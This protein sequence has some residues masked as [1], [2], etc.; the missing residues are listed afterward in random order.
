MKKILLIFIAIL[1]SV[2]AYSGNSPRIKFEDLLITAELEP[3]IFLEVRKLSAEQNLPMTIL[4]RDKKLFNACGIEDG[5]VVYAF[6]SD[7]LNPF[8]NGKT[9]FFEEV[10]NLFNPSESK[11][12]YGDGRVIDNTYGMFSP[13]LQS[14]SGVKEFL[15]VTDWTFDRVYLFDAQN[16]DLVDTAFIHSSNPQLQSPKHA[17]QTYYGTQILV[18]D[19]ISD[20]VQ[21]FDTN[22]LYVNLFAPAGGVNTSILDNIRGIAYKPNNHLL[23]TVASGASQNTIQEF[24]TAGVHVGSFITSNVNSPFCILYRSGD[25]LVSNSS[26]TNRITKFNFNGGF[27]SSFYTGTNFA[28]PQQ[29]IQLE[30]GRII[31]A[32]FSNPSGVVVLDSTGNFVR[33][34][35]AVTGIRGVYLLGNGNYMVTNSGGV[36]EIDS[37]SGAMI[38]TIVTGANYQYIDKYIPD[39]LVNIGN[40]PQYSFDYRLY[41]NYPNP[42]NPSTVIRFSIAKS[43][44][45]LLNIYDISGK[46]I[47]T[48]LNEVMS[49]GIH[50]VTFN[51]ENLSSGV[52]FYEIETSDFRQSRKM[53]LVK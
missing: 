2:P 45:V 21:R 26:G 44:N 27:I 37:L 11:I 15:M 19:Q 16:G 39:G 24:D 25:I 40:N 5:K 4:T 18:S 6:I 14:R 13:V 52:Y 38:R 53:L 49:P 36:H 22:G 28:F 47:K 12:I 29:I 33:I 17:M 1:F 20:A 41:E 35:N 48:L 3:S 43:E 42:F 9:L 30:D 31:V 50:E 34:M 7:L 51:A 8:N 23:V 32:A 10:I 46:K